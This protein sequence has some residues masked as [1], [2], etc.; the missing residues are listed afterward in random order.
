M[1]KTQQEYKAAIDRAMAAGDRQ[2]AEELARMAAYLYGDYTPQAESQFG[3]TLAQGV[4]FGFGV[5]I[6]AGAR[7]AA[8]MLG[9]SEDDRGYQKIRDELRGK[10]AQ[11][12]QQNPGTAL[13]AELLGGIVP[14][15]L[16]GGLGL[17]AGAGRTG[18]TLARTAGI[19]AVEGAL[20]GVGYSER[21]G[22][23]RLA[24][25]PGGAVAGA[26]GSAALS[27]LGTGFRKFVI[28]KL[29]QRSA[30]AVQAELQ[31]LAEGT[32]KTIDEVIADVMDGKIIAEN[33]TLMATL[34]AYQ[35][36]LDEA[37][38]MIKERLPER[39][40][41]TRAAASSAL[42]R[43]LAPQIDDP[44]ILRGMQ[45]T[46]DELRLL[47][48]EDYQRAYETVPE[49]TPEIT[50]TLQ[51]ILQRLPAARTEVDN[52][53]STS[54][55]L[56][57]LFVPDEAG[58]ITLRRVPTLEDAEVIRRALD[59]EA[60]KLFRAGSGSLGRNYEDAASDLRKM[61]DEVYPD[62][63]ATRARAK[64]RRDIRDSFAEGRKA[65]SRN[66]DEVEIE[67]ERLKSNPQ[68][69]EAYRS[70]VMAS[71][72]N[73]LN[74]QPGAIERLANPDRQE[75]IILRTL[76]PDQS[77]DD[78]IARLD[79][80]AGSQRAAQD[81]LKGSQTA[82]TNIAAAQIGSRGSM[83]QTLRAATGDPLALAQI[84]GQQLAK[85]APDLSA[86]DRK[87]VVEVLLSED[88][89]FVRK[90]LVEKDGIQELVAKARMMIGA[91]RG[92]VT[93]QFGQMGGLLT[94]DFFA[95]AEGGNR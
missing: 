71:L 33:A 56:V 73:Q 64:L 39:A 27:G 2:A 32:G 52:I 63:D 36:S 37:G 35:S 9:L 31:R 17:A 14:G 90:K 83:E 89:E 34:R 11:Y 4:T 94:G 74:R 30:T 86:K 12:K 82:P 75:G 7:A 48:R 76:F 88:P 49:V 80:A 46:D 54:R 57:P 3:R 84:V 77:I 68:A 70:G 10:L 44:N 13:T 45:R 42:Q 41:E 67:V 29:P 59:E 95:P 78:V 24:D 28:E 38:A 85:A 87:K 25:A 18:A 81:I 20:A 15:L 19:G 40:R 92:S 50:S 16:T 66:A 69:L 26:I 72:R 5:E 91:G 62:L 93:Q 23:Q 65:M 1:Q 60:T 21:E 51:D 8:G 43:E 53:Y 22:L 61:L 6:E 47:E 79:I 58:A 55:T